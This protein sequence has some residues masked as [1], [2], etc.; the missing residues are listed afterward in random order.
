[1]TRTIL[2]L[3][4]T[5]WALKPVQA[6]QVF[7]Y[8]HQG[9]WGI[10]DKNGQV[11][12]PPALDSIGLFS[13]DNGESMHLAVARKG[14]KSGLITP[15]GAWVLKPSVDSIL[16]LAQPRLRWAVLG[17]KYGLLHVDGKKAKWLTKPIFDEVDF[18]AQG[19]KPL[20]RVRQGSGWGVLQTTGKLL[21]PCVNEE[22]SIYSDFEQ[23]LYVHITNKGKI[24]RIADNGTPMAEEEA[25][26]F[27]QDITDED[28][29]ESWPKRKVEYRTRVADLENLPSVVMLE[30]STDHSTWK[31]V[32]HVVIPQGCEVKHVEQDFGKIV[33]IMI[34]RSGK[35]GF[36]NEVG[37]FITEPIYDRVSW[38]K[39]NYHPPVA[40]LYL[41]DRVGVAGQDGR[42]TLPPQFSQI[43][44]KGDRLMVSTP[45][46]YQGWAEPTGE[47]HLPAGW[48]E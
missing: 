17:G 5:L 45:N 24:T 19:K 26:Y 41:G 33:H 25:V 7:P 44:V 36:V 37:A 21:V 34:A 20:V 11:T 38:H 31:I 39:G 23:G 13:L 1:M 28:I 4:M 12:M 27:A 47:V 15:A 40:L 22:V 32:K 16:W 8:A 42:Q 30:S 18:F 10:V 29:E 35:F 46:G 2:T 9:K 48:R 43:Q 3:C 14:G 6:Q